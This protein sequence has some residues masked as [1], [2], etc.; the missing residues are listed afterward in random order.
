MHTVI[1]QIVEHSPEPIVMA[2]LIIYEY[3]VLCVKT[4]K[5]GLR[6]CILLCNFNRS[7]IFILSTLKYMRSRS[8][9]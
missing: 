1:V 7:Y 5:P 6:V 9:T 4:Q 3:A 8:G 2:V